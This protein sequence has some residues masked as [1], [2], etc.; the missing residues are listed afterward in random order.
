MLTNKVVLI[1]GAAHRI[2]ATTARLLHAEG[3][4]ILLDRWGCDVLLAENQAEASQQV[5]L[6]GTPDFV[7]VDYHLSDQRHGLQEMQ[8]IDEIL[9]TR[10]PAIVITA[11]RSKDLEEAVREQG[12]GLLRKPIRPAALRALMSNM[13]KA[14]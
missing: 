13:L 9:G 6:H 4:N 8:R 12:Y 2:G 14:Q 10:L 11:D 1:T 7:L 5:L 3:M